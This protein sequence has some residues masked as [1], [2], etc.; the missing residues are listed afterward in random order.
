M[1]VNTDFQIP[2]EKGKMVLDPPAKILNLIEQ[3]LLFS[4]R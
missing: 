4:E 3:P 2:P 1:E